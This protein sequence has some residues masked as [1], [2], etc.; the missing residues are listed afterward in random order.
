M[1]HESF[2]DEATAKVMN[3]HFVCIKVDREERPDIDQVY[4]TAVQLMTGSGGWPLNCFTLPDGRPV[5]GGTYFPNAAWNNVL[6]ELSNFYKTNPK[7]AG[8]YADEL[9]NGMRQAELVQLNNSEEQFQF[10]D[11]K[12]MV[13]NWKRSF[14][15]VHGGPNRAPK[16]P[17][18]NNLEFLLNYFHASKDEDILNQV[19]L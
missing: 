3:E 13:E 6:T 9:I 10:G 11:L 15:P 1:E 19:K 17:M 2:E 16:F 12:M 7:Q 14:D 18:P 8:A 5:Y 4:M